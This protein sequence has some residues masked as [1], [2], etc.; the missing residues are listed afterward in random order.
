MEG[1][2]MEDNK[3]SMWRRKIEELKKL[4]DKC[5]Q[6]SNKSTSLRNAILGVSPKMKKE[7]VKPELGGDGFNSQ[8]SS[9]IDEIRNEL[10]LINENLD[11]IF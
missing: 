10:D 6:V 5:H 8:F 9:L 11:E 4:V 2:E 3:E 1:N 7:I